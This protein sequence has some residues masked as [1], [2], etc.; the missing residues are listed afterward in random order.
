MN[1]QQITIEKVISK[2]ESIED[3]LLEVLP[4]TDEEHKEEVLDICCLLRQ[5]AKMYMNN[6]GVN[7]GAEV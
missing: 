6:Y 1:Q 7:E 4:S 3:L 5:R 2:I